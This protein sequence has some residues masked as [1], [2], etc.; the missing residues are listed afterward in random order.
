MPTSAIGFNGSLRFHSSRGLGRNTRSPRVAKCDGLLIY[1]RNYKVFFFRHDF[2]FIGG[3]G[4]CTFT[5]ISDLSQKNK[6][7]WF[8]FWWNDLFIG[9]L[10][11]FLM[12]ALFVKGLILIKHP[13]L[14][15]LIE[16][17]K[18]LNN[19]Y[20]LKQFLLRNNKNCAHFPVYYKFFIF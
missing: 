20:S 7:L 1:G 3:S 18:L 4:C 2:V 12:H 6:V 8:R 5:T 11:V 16:R 10:S 15:R 17:K 13:S 9:H 19:E 14:Q